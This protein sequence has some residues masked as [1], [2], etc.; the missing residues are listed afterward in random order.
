MKG[1][2]FWKKLSKTKKTK[3]SSDSCG[4]LRKARLLMTPCRPVLDLIIVDV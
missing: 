3:K 1:V 4:R 2:N